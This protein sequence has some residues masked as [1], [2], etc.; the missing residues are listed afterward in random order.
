MTTAWWDD[1]WLNESFAT[2]METKI[3]GE[4]K[5][6][7]KMPVTVVQSSLGVM[8]L[9]SLAS[10]RRIRQPIENDSDI[11][12]AFDS[13]SYEKGAAVIGMF[14]SWLGEKAFQNGVRQYMKQFADRAAT[15]ADFLA[16]VGKG[17]M[18]P[19]RSTRSWTRPACRW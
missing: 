1:V 14:E 13:I 15:T 17:A 18:S 16:A 8:G 4:W 6:E 7:W 10:T 12:N 2:W 3:A 9:D 11:A 5:P 19:D